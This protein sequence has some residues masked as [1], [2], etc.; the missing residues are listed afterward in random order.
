MGNQKN[1]AGAKESALTPVSPNANLPT[2]HNEVID[3]TTLFERVAAIIENRKYRTYAHAN[4]ETTLMFWEVGQYINSTVLGNQRAAY[5]KQILPTLSAELVAKYGKN[6]SERNIYRM[7]LFAERFPDIEILPTLSAKLSWS[8]ILEM[9]PL[10][11]TEAQLYYANEVAA[12]N[13]GVHEL[14][15]QISRK[16]YERREIA[17]AELSE[18]SAVP[19][20][21][22]KDP[23]LLDML[24]LK[25]NYLEA[26]LEKA[27]LA[28]IEAFI[29]EFGHGFS[30]VERQKR[31]IV[32]GEDIVL[33]MLFYHRIMKRLVAIELKLGRF[34]AAYMGQML[35]YLKWLDRYERQE[36]EEAPIG[37]V[38]CATANREKIELLEMDKAG[39]AVAEYWTHLPP[40]AEF[41]AKIKAIMV[42]A[43]ERLERRKSLPGSDVQRE[44]DYFIEPKDDEDE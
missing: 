29:L 3:E 6:F 2:Q 4:T 25:D 8:H 24:A 12:R 21:V 1:K 17:N 16:A 18:Q 7:S 14:R 44:I 5:G 34:K 27:I 23:Y 43:K 11:S 40:E 39:I 32:D 31:M 28:D 19:F 22:F 20:N 33:D 37:I 9:L 13:W 15:R 10:E 26:D 35:L 41:E 30:F 38:L 42:E 36:G